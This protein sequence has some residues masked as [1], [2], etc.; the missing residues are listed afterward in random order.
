MP[1]PGVE[2]AFRIV[3]AVAIPN[4][5]NTEFE[6]SGKIAELKLELS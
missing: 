1:G 4:L 6:I 5:Y 2:H 3:Y